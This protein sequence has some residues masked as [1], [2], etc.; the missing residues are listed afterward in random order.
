LFYYYGALQKNNCRKKPEF[1]ALVFT[2]NKNAVT[3]SIMKKTIW[4]LLV[5]GILLVRSIFASDLFLRNTYYYVVFEE[6]YK[7]LPK[8]SLVL[9]MNDN[10]IAEV[11]H[12]FKS[13]MDI[14]GTGKLV[15][16]R[17][18]NYAGIKNRNIRYRVTSAPFGNGVGTCELIPFGSVAVDPKVIPL[19][20]VIYIKETEG[21]ALP[22]GTTHSGLWKAEDIGGAIKKDRVDLFVGDEILGKAAL[23][24]A[25]IKNLQP[26]TVTIVE[27][28]S[29]NSCVDQTL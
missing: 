9:D 26:L 13:A 11:S 27:H 23:M 19:G 28:P 15:D 18:I 8:N 6:R 1:S 24:R 10:I 4:M 12:L 2:F 3:L 21:M 5:A 25:G 22:D 16:G 7:D 20:S 29:E 17:V 14:E